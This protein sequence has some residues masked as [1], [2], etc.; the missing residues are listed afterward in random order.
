MQR[1]WPEFAGRG[2]GAA[3]APEDAKRYIDD[4]EDPVRNPV[5]P[6]LL[7]GEARRAYV[8]RMFDQIAKP[9]DRLNQIISLG[10]VG[11]W[12]ARA[13]EVAGAK[14]GETA[15]DLGCGT[16]DLLLLLKERVGEAG[17]VAGLDPSEEMLALARRKWEERGFAG[18]PDLRQG[19]AE[20]TGFPDAT[21]DLVTMGWVLRNVGDRNATYR[22]VL[23]ILKPGGR[24]VSLDMSRSS[25][26]PSRWAGALYL[27]GFMPVLVKVM[28]GDMESYRY[29]ARSTRRFPRAAELAR[30]WEAAGFRDVR[31]ESLN[32]GTIAIHRGDKEP[33]A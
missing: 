28:G 26:A 23:R 2:R 18:E 16:G 12:R 21:F 29:L 9:Y 19:V 7:E 14:P 22:E 13:M 31:Y 24:L 1:A 27:E 20:S 15:L 32:V 3:L 30:E 4:M 33:R 10:R 25:F 8:T 11:A 17:S 6:S 5:D